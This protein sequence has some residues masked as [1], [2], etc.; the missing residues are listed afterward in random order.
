[1]KIQ[2]DP[3]NSKVIGL[4]LVAS[5]LVVFLPFGFYTMAGF[6]ILYGGACLLIPQIL[7][8]SEEEAEIRS[9]KLRD[10][11]AQSSSAP[12][13]WYFSPVFLLPLI[14]ILAYLVYTLS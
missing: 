3:R 11:A 9:A 13:D 10:R 4:V 14:G 7:F 8:P 6:V 2:S 12:V 5:G 1:M